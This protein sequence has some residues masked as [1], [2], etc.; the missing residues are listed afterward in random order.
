MDV[1]KKLSEVDAEVLNEMPEGERVSI[2]LRWMRWSRRR[3]IRFALWVSKTT[4]WAVSFHL[5]LK[6]FLSVPSVSG[7]NK[8]SSSSARP[9]HFQATLSRDFERPQAG[10]KCFRWFFNVKP[11]CS[12]SVVLLGL[13]FPFLVRES[14]NKIVCFC[15]RHVV[16]IVCALAL[17]LAWREVLFLLQH[18]F[19]P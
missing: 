6:C 13:Y 2:V 10:N 1:I 4:E 12:S 7:L 14:C 16:R 18:S 8:R 19:G 9:H 15:S 3:R 5:E 11:A 17:R